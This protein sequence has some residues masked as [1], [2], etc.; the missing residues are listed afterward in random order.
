MGGCDHVN[1][2][3]PA[4]GKELWIASGTGIDHDW[5]RTIASP[6]AGDGIVFVPSASTQGLG[7][8]VAVRA[9]GNGDVTATGRLWQYDK[10]TPDCLSPLYHEGLVYAVRDDGIASCLDARTGELLWKKCLGR[11]EFKASPL[12]GDGKVYFLATN[13]EC[14][15][16]EAGREGTII[17]ENQLEGSFIATPAIA[18]GRIYFR[19][20]DR[21]YAVGPAP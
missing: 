2:Y 21:V 3:D 14:L 16:L 7:K 8:L 19:A 17:A 4:T 10:F 18:G 12:A 11:G 5:G 1:A 20:S 15:V 9:G 13:G 6:C